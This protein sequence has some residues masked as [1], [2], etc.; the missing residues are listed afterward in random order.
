M[1]DVFDEGIITVPINFVTDFAS[2]P[3][4]LYK[5]LR[6]DGPWDRASVIH[7]FLCR[8]ANHDKETAM[9][10]KHADDIFYEAARSDGVWVVTAFLF[11]GTI[12]IFH[13]FSG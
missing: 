13:K 5:V 12:R 1:S 7:D 6:P 8:M 11:W 9:D 4:P 10:Y 3:W 2:I